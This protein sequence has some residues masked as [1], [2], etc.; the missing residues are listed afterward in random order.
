MEL[1]LDFTAFLPTHLCPTY[2]KVVS[3]LNQT[4][5]AFPKGAAMLTGNRG[6][7]TIKVYDKVKAKD[8]VGKA[9]Q[10]FYEGEKSNKFVKVVIQEKVRTQRWTK[11][12]YVTLMGFDREPADT[13]SNNKVDKLL[14]QF[15][16]V[17]EP[18]QDVFAENFLTG[19]KKVRIDLNKEIDIPRNFHIQ[20]ELASGRNLTVSLRV[21]YRDQPY[22]CRRCTEQHVGDCPLYIAEK[23]EKT[24]IKKVKEDSSK[25]MLVGDS[26]FR[27]VNENG[28][29]ATVTAVTGG[30]LG[31]II[32]QVSFEDLTKIDTVVLSAGQN[33]TNDVE[34]VGQEAWESRTKAEF[35]K[36]EKA[37]LSLITKGKN[38]IM[39]PVPPAPCTQVSTSKKKARV[40][41]NDAIMH[42]I[43]KVNQGDS[44]PGSVGIL[45]ESDGEYD[46]ETDFTDE[47]HLS[48]HAMERRLSCLDD[49]L[50]EGKKLRTSTLSARATCDPYRGCYGAHPAG[51]IICTGMN[52]NAHTCKFS[53]KL[54]G[55]RDKVSGSQSP[56]HKSQRTG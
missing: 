25:T 45:T 55:K 6:I 13:L 26:N 17:I 4:V 56:E 27:C 33:C 34:E 5:S 32:N 48:K 16:T 53:E 1:E 36:A 52:H 31:H 14:S 51:C 11:P 22:H 21:Y 28:V 40:F 35:A 24:K 47:R 9:V 43:K 29:M 38:V 49:I 41:V 2:T 39:L 19:K 3:L 12:R 8:L 20:V 50:P 23:E 42:L 46:M 37:L 44:K 30:K 15:G 18:T 7:F 54:R 10:Y